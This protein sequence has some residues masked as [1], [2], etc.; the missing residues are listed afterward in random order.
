MI[1]VG[2]GANLPHPIYGS[3]RRTC[4]AALA[5]LVDR[6][7]RFATRSRW[8]ASEPLV[9]GGGSGPSNQP[10][11][12]NGAVAVET[13]LEPT[14]LLE[15]LLRVEEAFGR[16]RSVPDAPRTLDLDVLTFDNQVIE[17]DNLT[18]PHPRI[19]ERAFV[20]LPIADI[21]PEW[22]HPRTGVSVADM[23]AALGDD[24]GIRI[25]PDAKG[26]MGTEWDGDGRSD[27]VTDSKH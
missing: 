9:R 24:Q 26:F 21:A 1:I 20:L 3:P 16:M 12:V 25:L 8:Y 14:E 4:G 27:E 13:R 5:T 17:L 19:H 2:I 15:A 23:I 10:W 22:C 7:I 18:V 11:Y 6:G